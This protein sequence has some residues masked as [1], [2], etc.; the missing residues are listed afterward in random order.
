MQNPFPGMNPY[1]EMFWR[2][3]HSRLN[4]QICDALNDQLPTELVAIIE[5]RVYVELPDLENRPVYPDIRVLQHRRP[6]KEATEPDAPVAV[7][8][9][10]RTEPLFIEIESE[11]IT[12]HFVNIIEV[13]GE[14]VI[15]SIE[16]LSVANKIRG[17]GQAQYLKKQVETIEAGINLV[18]ID[19]LR[20]GEWILSLPDGYISA[21]YR[22]PYRVCV[23][24]AERPG[25]REFYPIHLEEPLPAVSIPLRAGEADVV[26][27][28]Q[29]LI[30][31]AYEQGRYH[32]LIDY[33]QAPP[34]PL[35]DAQRQWIDQILREKGLRQ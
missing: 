30:N 1:L 23:F 33:I 16:V 6:P 20:T 9:R 5:E 27:E 25:A 2:S 13:H 34:A 24:R 21:K 10:T 4:V 11:P 3:M 19:L 22:T 35:T 31:R 29:P 26:L 7:A 8:E 17:T 32:R 14:R 12:E 28:L 18:E 15:T